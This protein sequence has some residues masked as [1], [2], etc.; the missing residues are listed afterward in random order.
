[1]IT[2]GITT[3]NRKK[4][5]T[6]MAQSLKESWGLEDCSIRIYD[7]ASDEYDESFLRELFPNANT[8]IRH[9]R[10]M[11]ASA[12][13]QFMY[14]DFLNYDDEYLFNAD[15][16]LIYNKAWLQEGIRLIKQTDGI[17]S[18]F[19]TGVHEVT[20]DL[21]E[22]CEKVDVGSAGTLLAKKIVQLICEG[23]T[24]DIDK[25]FDYAWCRLLRDGG[26][27]FYTS[28]N[29]YVQHIGLSGVNSNKNRFDFG[30]GYA[31]DSTLNGQ[32]LNDV[33]NDYSKDMNEYWKIHKDYMYLFPYEYVM[34]N[35]NV[36]V[37][38]CGNV[39][40]DFL[41]QLRASN[42]C[43]VVAIVDGS[44]NPELNTIRPSELVN[45]N[46]DYIVI[47]TINTGFIDEI[48][49]NLKKLNIYDENRVIVN[50]NYPKVPL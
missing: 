21:G 13:I 47:A 29:S 41:R 40:K 7:D 42:Y 45:I 36:V 24:Y 23:I 11:G 30:D 34:P 1:M 3:H 43:N 18:L 35:S 15:S 20:N 48:I 44:M 39:G 12:N 28:K 37:Y 33:L 17:L 26:K 2:I 27:K 32:I 6:M 19:N 16:D 14:R 31:V 4:I 38:G 49:E 46:Y 5:V 9:K 50:I 25:G 22:I 10:N 8:I